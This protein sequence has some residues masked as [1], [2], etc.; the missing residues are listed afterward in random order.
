MPFTLAHPAVV[1]PLFRR[2]FVPAALVAGA[3]APDAPYFLAALGISATSSEDWYEPF[4][5]ATVTHSPLGLLLGLPATV[6]L[7]LLYWALRQP[8]AALLQAATPPLDVRNKV[9][10]GGWLL[11]SGVIGIA[12]HLGWDYLTHGDYLPSGAREASI[13]GG[14]SGPRLLQYGSTAIGLVA[15]GWH[16]WRHRQRSRASTGLKPAWRWGIAA[17]LI[18]VPLLGGLA[19]V[20]QDYNT[21]QTVT[22]VDYDHPIVVDEGNGVTSTS[23]P[24]TTADAPWGV[25]AE[26]V[27]TGFAKRAGAAFLVALLLYATAWHLVAARRRIR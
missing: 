27:L 22:N 24:T 20:P 6:A 9:Q 3:M 11:V 8:L 14:L 21:F 13:I 2:P 4:V 16:L 7:V 10:Y 12:T 17:L 5:N 18:A 26:G 15:I 23:Y 1:L 19:A 25:V